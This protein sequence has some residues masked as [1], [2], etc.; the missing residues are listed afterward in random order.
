MGNNID[1]KRE[2]LAMQMVNLEGRGERYEKLFGHREY[3]YLFSFLIPYGSLLEK[4]DPLYTL[5]A[6][7]NKDNDQSNNFWVEGIKKL[8]PLDEVFICEI[9]GTKI[10]SLSNLGAKVFCYD[11]PN[12]VDLENYKEVMKNSPLEFDL[13]ATRMVF[14]PGS[15]I[16][17]ISKTN[18]AAYR[19]CTAERELGAVLS[20][21]TKK[22][23]Y[24]VNAP[25]P[26]LGESLGFERLLYIREFPGLR[27]HK[28]ISEP[29]IDSV[30][31]KNIDFGYILRSTSK[32]KV[33]LIKEPLF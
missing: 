15:C 7:F 4:L 33:V 10:G 5:N 6:R 22:G 17:E 8:R 21:I 32:G 20:N 28:K 24:S 12:L 1:S 2:E 9:G 25:G 30:L 27:V 16:E 19:Y 23:G 29:N 18:N 11:Y 31:G 3:S 14:D 13:T 26:Y